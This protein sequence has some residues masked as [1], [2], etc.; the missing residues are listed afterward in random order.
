M[1]DISSCRWNLAELGRLDAEPGYCFRRGPA[2]VGRLAE[3]GL[4]TGVA[5]RESA[6]TADGAGDGEV[7]AK[8]WRDEIPLTGEWLDEHP[9]AIDICCSWPW[10]WPWP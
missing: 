8:P 2:E 7:D 10:P 5:A 4:G 6:H 3:G 9:S 1:D